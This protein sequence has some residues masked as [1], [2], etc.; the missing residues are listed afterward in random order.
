MLKQELE[1]VEFY[2]EQ[3]YADIA[4]DTLDMLERQYGA[5]AEIEQ[6]LYQTR[7]SRR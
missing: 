5:H 3:G 6:L 7:D 2:I 4:R 1:S